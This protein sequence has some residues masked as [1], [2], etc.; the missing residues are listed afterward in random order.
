MT[1]DPRLV[2]AP[3]ADDEADLAAL[4]EHDADLGDSEITRSLLTIFE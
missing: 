4:R 2:L 1:T 3:R